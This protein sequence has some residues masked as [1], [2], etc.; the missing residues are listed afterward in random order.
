MWGSRS[1]LRTTRRRSDKPRHAGDERV[2][3]RFAG[4]GAAVEVEQEAVTPSLSRKAGSGGSSAGCRGRDASSLPRLEKNDKIDPRTRASQRG[5]TEDG[6]PTA[7]AYFL[8]HIF[9][10]YS[11]DSPSSSA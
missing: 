2:F 4:S 1:S 8:H 3:E 7:P 9:P 11:A 5:R 6:S 10:P